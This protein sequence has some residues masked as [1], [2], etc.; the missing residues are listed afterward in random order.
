M[1]HHHTCAEMAH[2]SVIVRPKLFFSFRVFLQ[3]L[4]Q[5]EINSQKHA[6]PDTDLSARAYPLNSVPNQNKGAYAGG[7]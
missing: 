6:I 4:A 2:P 1:Q 5:R 3:T 7:S